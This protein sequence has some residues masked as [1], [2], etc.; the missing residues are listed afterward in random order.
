MIIF[1]KYDKFS[2]PPRKDRSKAV[3]W[4]E[5]SY[6]YAVIFMKLSNQVHAQ[7]HW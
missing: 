5:T 3:P 2:I 1:L 7:Y 6:D 4:L